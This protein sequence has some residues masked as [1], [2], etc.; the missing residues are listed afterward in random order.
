V[1]DARHH[2]RPFYATKHHFQNT[3]DAIFNPYSNTFDDSL[4]TTRNSHRKYLPDKV[5]NQDNAQEFGTILRQRR[6]MSIPA[7]R[8]QHV[9]QSYAKRKVLQG[10]DLHIDQGECFGLVGVNG[11]GKTSLIKCLFD[12]NALDEGSIAIFGQDH[13]QP[14]ARQP[15]AFLPERFVPPYYLTGLD[16]LK[17]ILKLQGIA[18]DGAAAARMLQALALEQEALQR[19]VRSYSK[20]MTQKLGLVACLLAGKQLTVLD[21]PMS[22]LDPK[23]RSLLKQ[24]LRALRQA[25]ATVFFTSHALADV[26]EMCDRMA[27]LHD[28]RLR[29][30]GTPAQCR[31]AHAG[32]APEPSLEQAFMNC[33]H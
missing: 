24:Q 10:I 1:F 26:E 2:L 4:C 28:G 33:I 14:A 8:F 31:A 12:F 3:K 20:G 25:G 27:I 30:I 5:K 16:F 23:A 22:G 29:F 18:Y 6:S 19:T 15:L 32:A 17:Y 21:E 11:A 7:L 13:R 9:V